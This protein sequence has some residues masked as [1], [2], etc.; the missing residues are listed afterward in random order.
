MVL[1]F[2]QKPLSQWQ[3]SAAGAVLRSALLQDRP[4]FADCELDFIS[5]P[6]LEFPPSRR[7]ERYTWAKLKPLN[8]NDL[9]RFWKQFCAAWSDYKSREPREVKRRRPPDL[10]TG[11]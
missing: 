6:L 2:W 3:L 11:R 7:F 1:H 8:A 4:A 5:V 10:L 9:L